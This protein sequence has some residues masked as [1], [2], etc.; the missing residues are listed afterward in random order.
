LTMSSSTVPAKTTMMGAVIH[1]DRRGAPN[2]S[3]TGDLFPALELRQDLPIPDPGEVRS[4]IGEEAYNALVNCGESDEA[5]GDLRLIK[6]LRGGICGTDIHM[7]KG[8]VDDAVAVDGKSPLVLGHEFVGIDTKTN[9]RVVA[10]INIPC[11]RC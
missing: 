10:G 8:Y 4:A 11:G 9:R 7:L 2:Q 5:G 1:C 6:V 3:G